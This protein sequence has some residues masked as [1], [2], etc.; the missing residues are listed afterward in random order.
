MGAALRSCVCTAGFVNLYEGVRHVEEEGVMR[1]KEGGGGCSG[2]D[3]P[4]LHFFLSLCLS[5]ELLHSALRISFVLHA[6]RMSTATASTGAAQP[7][8]PQPPKDNRIPVTIDGIQIKVEPGTTILQV[9]MSPNP[10][11]PREE[12]HIT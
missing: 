2:D 8:A 1:A 12:P 7:A 4:N 6:V 11:G 10:L 3:G 9:R 5:W